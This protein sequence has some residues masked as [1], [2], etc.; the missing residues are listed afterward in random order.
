MRLSS[1]IVC[2][3]AVLLHCK[4]T[5]AQTQLELNIASRAKFE[6]ADAKLNEAYKILLPQL[7]DDGRKKLQEAQKAWITFRDADAESEADDYLGG[8]IWPLIFNDCLT[9]RTESRTAELELRIKE[10]ASH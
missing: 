2:T 7:N 6:K 3:F 5:F 8:S 4:C 9:A 1:I 10:L